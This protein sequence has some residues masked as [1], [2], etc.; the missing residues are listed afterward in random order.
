[1]DP[2]PQ[3][4]LEIEI[5]TFFQ[6]KWSL[7]RR[8][9]RTIIPDKANSLRLNGFENVADMY[10]RASAP[11]AQ[12]H[13]KNGDKYYF[14]E[15]IPQ[16]NLFDDVRINSLFERDPAKFGWLRYDD[17]RWN[18]GDPLVNLH[19]IQQ[20]LVTDCKRQQ[21]TDRYLVSFDRVVVV[22]NSSGAINS[23]PFLGS[24]VTEKQRFVQR[25]R[26]SR[27]LF[28]DIRD[29]SFVVTFKKFAA[30]ILRLAIKLH[31][32]MSIVSHTY[33]S[34]LE[35]FIAQI[36]LD[37]NGNRYMN[38]TLVKSYGEFH[39]EVFKDRQKEGMSSE[40]NKIR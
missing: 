21:Y 25:I 31:Q 15:D 13:L 11:T 4:K 10:I 35:N 34:Y 12:Y 6:E 40:I 19:N 14:F 1:M 39:I 29:R 26:Y 22:R 32:K 20:P 27:S 9:T 24:G 23:E 18:V 8:Y 28:G 30:P 7:F 33:A 38:I 5:Y 16:F 17:G 2:R 3:A 36:C 37:K